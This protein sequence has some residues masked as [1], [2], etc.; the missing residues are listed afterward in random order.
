M[1]RI[2]PQSFN[3]KRRS[4]LITIIGLVSL[5]VSPGGLGG[6]LPSARAAAAA[7]AFVVNS[8]GDGSDVNTS[9]G[10]CD[11][12]T[13]HC[14][15]RAAIEQANATP[16]T[17]TISFNIGS[18]GLQTITLAKTPPDVTDPVVIDGTTQPGYSGAPLVEILGAVNVQPPISWALR[19]T[20][21]SSTVRG[22]AIGRLSVSGI[23]LG[24][25]GGGEHGGNK[26]ESCYI[27]L[28]A[29][30][31]TPAPMGGGCVAV[32]NSPDNLIGG[33]S[34][35][36]RN[37]LS[38]CGSGVQITG[39]PSTGNLVQGNYVGTD[40]AGAAA[41]TPVGFLGSGVLLGS[42]ASNN[43]IGGIAS[44]SGNLISGNPT[45]GVVTVNTTSG[46]KIQGNLIGLAA[47]GK[48]ALPNGTNG[49]DLSSATGYLIGGT[50][51]GAG[52]VISGNKGHGVLILGG[53]GSNTIQG[54]FIG[55]NAAGDA[56]RPNN[57]D[58]VRISASPNNLIGGTT[59]GARNVISGNDQQGVYILNNTAT[60][61][62][63]AGNYIGTNAA[64]TASVFNG[65]NG[66]R[67]E[68]SQNTVG[69][70]T[71]AARNVISGN[72]SYGVSVE[73][74]QSSVVQGNYIGTNADGTGDV[75]NLSGGVRDRGTGTLIGGLT[76]TPG[77]A[78][79]N[80]ISGNQTAIDIVFTASQT[81]IRGN[82]LG[83]NPAGTAKLIDQSYGILGANTTTI[84]GGVDP[85]ARNVISGFKVGIFGT[86]TIQ[87]NYI[88]TDT[89]GT[90]AI[91]N[92]EFGIQASNSAVIG[93]TTAGA[94]NVISGNAG[95]I[96]LTGSSVT[97]QGNYIGA[98]AS[99][100]PLPNAR[101][102]VLFA[103]GT[104]DNVVGGTAA[105]AANLIAFNGGSGIVVP[106]D[107]TIGFGLPANNSFRANS[108]HSNA[109]LGIDLIA[110]TPQLQSPILDYD[111]PTQN[112][113]GDPDAGPN[114]LQNY[115]L[116]LSVTAG[117]GNTNVGGTLNSKASAAYTLDFYANTSCDPS[118]HGEGQTFFGST[119]VTTDSNGNASFNAS[120]PTPASGQAFTAT[121][122]DAS[123]NTSEFS[124]CHE[125]GAPG[126]V[127]FDSASFA[128]K[129]G[130][131]SA[132]V[133]VTRTLGSAGAAT[134]DY[135]TSDGTAKAVEDY[136]PASGTL[137]FAAGE[138]TKSFTVA[139]LDDSSDED[140]ETVNLSLSNPTGG[141]VLG[142]N[143]S[144]AIN[145]TDNDPEPTLSFAYSN[146]FVAEG[147]SGTAEAV[148]TVR[149]SAPSGKTVTVNY[150]TGD[151]Q[152]MSG[153][154]YQPASGTLAFAPGETAKSVTVLVNGDT[155]PEPDE[156]FLLTLSG[157]VNAGFV[158]GQM[159]AL[160]VGFVWDDD[161]AGI[162][163]SAPN[164]TVAERGGSVTIG[165]VR[166]GN[167]SAAE[168][169]FYSATGGMAP[170]DSL[171][172]SRHDFTEARGRLDFVPG[173]TA[174]S[175]TVLV[176][177]DSYVEGDEHVI[178]T[179]VPANT[180]TFLLADLT[181]TSED[182]SPPQPNPV[183]GSEFYVRQH[184]HDFLNR[185]PDASGLAFWT[186]EIESCGQDSQCRE[187]K[188]INVSA[189]FFLSI[190]FQNTG[191]FAYRTYKSAYGDATSP[192]VSGTVPA[193]RLSEF[194]TDARRIGQGITVGVG[195]WQQQLEDNKNAYALEFVATERFLAAYP[196]TMSADEFVSKLD[197]NAGGVLSASEKA[198]LVASLGA[199]PAD[200]QKRAAVLRAV[201]DDPDLNRAEFNRAFVL[202]QYF[203]YLRRNPDEQPE[204]GLNYGGWKFWLDK[205][206]LFNGNFVSAEMVKAFISSDEYRHRFGQ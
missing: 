127:Q 169:V 22:L 33:T 74:G 144:S 161:S 95:G 4:L 147:N 175:F 91:P 93:G 165:V 28:R 180:D 164:Y 198:Q 80:L 50:A 109:L 171:A 94:R 176:N 167:A 54:N 138:T 100:A 157:P 52:N 196:A 49:I 12:G 85:G 39:A 193:I 195:N 188:R 179:L 36:A 128:V 114:G 8:N 48:T 150:G 183:D 92:R 38:G 201:A 106:S 27:G 117:G 162:H 79:G 103:S 123:G 44:G 177:D 173:E 16:G 90:T 197:Q 25:V 190:E 119:Q 69:G 107:S 110:A 58:G 206:N 187:V 189:A 148:F 178:L 76:P 84:I 88:G 108:I 184:Y 30:G 6:S 170:L 18:G 1:P 199:T 122:T 204:P 140:V 152:A 163:F 105:G 60:N 181:I 47:D 120:F 75:Q 42:D 41:V 205:L 111:G 23:L 77:A 43:T 113:A 61:N 32:V 46:N 57:L 45:G 24:G 73:S 186:N 10:V 200:A 71:P 83:T 96:W 7:A 182:T 15:Y 102:G 98:S 21:G 135:S 151:G 166:R 56:R 185:E 124:V 34:A 116:L 194:L 87:G 158:S 66:V 137:S 89:S 156:Q 78:P 2:I 72:R 62:V 67:V 139:I 191:Y 118:G 146:V 53:S 141:I 17:D 202:M 143:S 59:A 149:L 153:V 130:V 145:I 154:D 132:T 13:G 112:D 64:G 40:A 86:G 203:G 134:V 142:G 160:A 159:Q 5:M 11:D 3:F 81:T 55:T 19:I 31:V 168:S 126:T 192:G 104:H 63:V 172:S 131:A 125:A 174:K 68:F 14:T 99:G 129:E 65:D 115:P 101:H 51:D 35:A 9:D 136:T 20:A 133:T 121:A 37:V 29:D 97:V 26:V 82:L 70:T 155:T